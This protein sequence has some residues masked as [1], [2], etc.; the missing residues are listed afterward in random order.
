MT[1]RVLVVDPDPDAD[2]LY[3]SCLRDAGYGA[4][5]VRTAAS[6]LVEARRQRPDVIL[7]ERPVDGVDVCRLVRTDTTCAATPLVVVAH[8]CAIED[9]IA[10]FEAGADD[11]VAKPFS[12]RELALRVRALLRRAKARHDEP[13]STLRV[14]PIEIDVP[15]RRVRVGTREVP[16]TRTEFRLLVHL[17]SRPGHVRTRSELLADVWKLDP[18]TAT[19]TVDTH[20]KRLRRKLGDA[21][22]RIE[23]VPR[24]GYRLRER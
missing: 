13:P 23:T 4:S 11:F 12:G 20:V 9:R 8:R 19:R 6:V 7:T 22:R 17:A 16:L 3:E 21:A 24:V 2:S 18:D 10:A 14:G 15:R 1:E 5:F